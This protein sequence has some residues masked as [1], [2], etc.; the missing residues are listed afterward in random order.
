MSPSTT[1][2]AARLL[3]QARAGGPPLDAL[4]ENLRP[5][6]I[7]QAYAI[8]DA[9]NRQL[10]RIAGWKVSPLRGTAPPNCAPIGAALIHPSPARLALGTLPRAEVEAE[11]AVT[12]GQDLPP[13][14][15]PYGREDM[16]AAIASVHPALEVVHSR[17]QD[18]ASVPQPSVVADSQGN[19]ALVLG[20]GLRDWQGL[21]LG[22]VAMRLRIGGAEVAAAEGGF[23]TANVLASLAWLANHVALRTGGL[24]RGDVV[25]TGARAGPK[26][27]G[28]TPT[29]V[30]AEARGLGR[31]EVTFD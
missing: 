2:Q 20:P 13:R 6:T 17:F 15:T 3:L 18:R 31:A 9:V 28:P 10:G 12:L 8:Q 22:G 4:P 27:V 1:D 16:R 24:K 21:E 7:E 30:L 29:A 26:L 14:D 23:D 5:A 25:L 11:I 19:A